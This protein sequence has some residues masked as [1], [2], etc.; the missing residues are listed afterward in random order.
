M[1]VF[2]DRRIWLYRELYRIKPLIKILPIKSQVFSDL[3]E[4]ITV[5]DKL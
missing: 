1:V 2:D 5:K 3:G 4:N